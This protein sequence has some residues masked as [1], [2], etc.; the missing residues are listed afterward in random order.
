MG[1]DEGL[2]L[3]KASIGTSSTLSMFVSTSLF[4]KRST[5]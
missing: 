5:R 3:V 2:G 4:Q 1:W